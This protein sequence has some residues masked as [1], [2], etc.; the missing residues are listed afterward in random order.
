MKKDSAVR[1]FRW[2]NTDV[3][4]ILSYPIFRFLRALVD[5]R[6]ILAD[7]HRKPT[8]PATGESV[9]DESRN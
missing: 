3:C 7:S 1:H 9:T 6:L 2:T 5:P 4:P 8:S